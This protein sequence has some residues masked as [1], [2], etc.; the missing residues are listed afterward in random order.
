MRKI[1]HIFLGAAVLVLCSLNFVGAEDSDD[2]VK[3]MEKKRAMIN[4]AKQ[5]LN[6]TVWEIELRQM[7]AGNKDNKK[8]ITDTLRFKDGKIESDRLVSEGFPPS[9]FTVR[10]KKDLIIWETMQRNEKE[11]VAFWRGESRETEDVMR[12]VLSWH[13]N[14][15]K[16][17]DYSFISKKSEALPEVIEE[18]VAPEMAQEE[19]AATEE[20]SPQPTQEIKEPEEIAPVVNEEVEKKEAVEVVQPKKE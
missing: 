1:T 12:G 18:E 7:A 8:A 19:A 14:K 3:E 9:N 16:V 5:G 10:L 4:A 6:N 13:I 11:G 17:T 20:I 15:K 2:K